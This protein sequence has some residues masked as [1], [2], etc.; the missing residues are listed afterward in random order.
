MTGHRTHSPTSS[1]DPHHDERRCSGN[2]VGHRI[3]DVTN[4]ELNATAD[5]SVVHMR[6]CKCNN[7]LNWLVTWRDPSRSVVALWRADWQPRS[8]TDRGP[9]VQQAWLARF[10]PIVHISVRTS[11]FFV[12]S[13]VADTKAGTGCEFGAREGG[14]LGD[15]GRQNRQGDRQG[16]GC[17]VVTASLD[18]D[19]NRTTQSEQLSSARPYH[20]SH[21]RVA[22]CSLSHPPLPP[23]PGAGAPSSS[24]PAVHSF[25]PGPSF[26]FAFAFV[27]R[28]R[29]SQ[30]FALRPVSS[31]MLLSGF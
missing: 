29:C 26:A 13:N 28:G 19:E 16:D 22:P 14:R 11:G 1:I 17:D 2:K 15:R 7:A 24:Q 20:A 6:C 18:F 31:E 27:I 9:Q 21:A 5:F 10:V 25:L 12:E 30:V 3:Q 23:F 8:Q 4:A